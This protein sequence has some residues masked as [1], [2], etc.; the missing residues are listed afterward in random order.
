MDPAYDKVQVKTLEE[1][2]EDFDGGIIILVPNDNFIQSKEKKRSLFG[3]FSTLVKPHAKLFALAIFVSILLTIFGII[4]SIFN[5]TLVDEIIPY[6]KESL[7]LSFGILLSVVVVTQALMGAFRSHVV[8]YLSQ[9]IDIPLMLGYFG[10]IFRL[11][12]KFFETRS[13]GDITT[14]FSDAGVVKSTL[15]NTALTLAIDI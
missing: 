2:N 7:I 3:S 5:K 12:M 13:T 4:M 1:F 14:R 9:K 8:L 15:T 10:H 6:Q 11:P